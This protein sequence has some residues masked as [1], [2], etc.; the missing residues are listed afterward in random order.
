MEKILG[1]VKQLLR[2]EIRMERNNPRCFIYFYAPLF[3]LALLCLPISSKWIL[4]LRS[5]TWQV[6]DTLKYHEQ[7]TVCLPLYFLESSAG[8]VSAVLGSGTNSAFR[9]CA[10]IVFDPQQGQCTAVT[11][12]IPVP[13][14]RSPDSD[15]WLNTAKFLCLDRFRGCPLG[16]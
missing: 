6:L 16:A 5:M 12:G 3:H 9:E 10:L 15:S 13:L 14:C 1:K 8:E 7:H 11:E 2:N 4:P